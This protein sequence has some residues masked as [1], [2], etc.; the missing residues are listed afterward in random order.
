MLEEKRP[1]TSWSL[2]RPRGRRPVEASSSRGFSKPPAARTTCRAATRK[3]VPAGV[4][5][6]SPVT[7]R[8]SASASI[9][10]TVACRCTVT[11]AA[12]RNSSRWER[13][14]APRRLRDLL[15]DAVEHPAARQRRR[16]GRVAG[17][18]VRRVPA[19]ALEAA[20][21]GRA[22][23]VATDLGLGDRPARVGDALAPLEVDRLERPG[24]PVPVR[25][26]A[27]EGPAVAPRRAGS[28]EARS[29]RPR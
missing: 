5:T 2:P 24:E 14:N 11:L 28:R 3:R 9:S 27:P 23:L 8:A 12:R 19:G 15:R 18:P 20:E 6:R 21:L 22:T 1:T 7:V 13:P 26:R 25:A 17:P 29:R 10:V 4:A 16:S